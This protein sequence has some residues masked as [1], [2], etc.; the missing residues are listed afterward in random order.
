MKTRLP[1]R[2]AD[3]G[4][5]F[6]TSRSSSSLNVV[7]QAMAGRASWKPEAVISAADTES[8]ASSRAITAGTNGRIA[9]TCSTDF[10]VSRQRLKSGS[11]VSR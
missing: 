8:S 10:N 7:V 1:E 11:G 9:L 6:G 4:D 2:I 3:H 5:R